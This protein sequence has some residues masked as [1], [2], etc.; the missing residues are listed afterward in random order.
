M[1][2][3]FTIKS[4]SNLEIQWFGKLNFKE[5][6]SNEIFWSF[7]SR[8]ALFIRGIE[9]IFFIRIVRTNQKL[10]VRTSNENKNKE[11]VIF[12]WNTEISNFATFD[13]KNKYMK[14][15]I[16]DFLNQYEHCHSIVS[17][18]KINGLKFQNNLNKHLNSFLDNCKKQLKKLNRNS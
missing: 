12:T 15:E 6:F 1:N 16:W 5:E 13:R 18:K 10:C 17:R 2:R 4:N 7:V 14:Y 9:T 8:K 11:L 3:Y